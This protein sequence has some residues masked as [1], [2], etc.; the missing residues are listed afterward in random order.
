MN[1]NIPYPPELQP[2]MDHYFITG[3]DIHLTNL[4]DVFKP[5]DNKD[6]NFNNKE[7]FSVEN[8]D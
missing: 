7:Y 6:N 2:L 1:T 5:V 4:S 8:K 3:Q